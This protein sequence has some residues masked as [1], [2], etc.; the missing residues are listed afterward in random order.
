MSLLDSTAGGI[1]LPEMVLPLVVQ[2]LRQRSTAIQVCTEIQTLSPTFRLPVVQLDAVSEWLVEGDDI[3]PTDPTIGEEVVR[4]TK[5][6]ALV[7]VSNE[8]ANDSSC[9]R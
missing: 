5:V 9:S 6:G 1:L 2:P 4:P 8:L 3:V 7:K